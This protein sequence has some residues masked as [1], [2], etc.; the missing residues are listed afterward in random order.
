MSDVLVALG[1]NPSV[2]CDPYYQVLVEIFTRTLTQALDPK[3]EIESTPIETLQ[4]RDKYLSAWGQI[5]QES[6]PGGKL[7]RYEDGDALHA[8]LLPVTH[9]EGDPERIRGER[10]WTAE[11]IAA[12]KEKRVTD[13]Y[14]A[15]SAPPGLAEAETRKQVT[16][17]LNMGGLR[18]PEN[19]PGDLDDV[20]SL[21]KGDA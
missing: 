19:E 9:V 13:P 12:H 14:E 18:N 3:V 11:E 7:E 1:K 2:A 15:R 8:V 16:K 21:R 20:R 6:L 10:R 4:K 17:A 5:P